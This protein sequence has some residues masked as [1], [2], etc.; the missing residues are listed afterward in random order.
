MLSRL[1]I[2]QC[3]RQNLMKFF[4][5]LLLCL[6][7][8]VSVLLVLKKKI[9]KRHWLATQ[10]PLR[11][12]MSKFLVLHSGDQTSINQNQCSSKVKQMLKK[13]LIKVLLE[14]NQFEL[15]MRKVQVLVMFHRKMLLVLYQVNQLGQ[16]SQPPGRGPV[17]VRVKFVTG[18]YAF[19]E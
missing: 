7:F 10:E 18:P 16:W 12:C 17:P 4:I 14:A 3:S 13:K 6:V 1:I 5:P 15:M 8:I 11:G 9:R 2:C 19:S